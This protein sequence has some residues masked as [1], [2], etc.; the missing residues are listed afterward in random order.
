MLCQ[1][2]TLKSGKFWHRGKRKVP[3]GPEVTI[4]LPRPKTLSEALAIA[5]FSINH[6]AVQ[7][8]RWQNAILNFLPS[9]IGLF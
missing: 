9:D 7:T 2:T 4:I 6:E 8:G 1:H 5:R 3:S